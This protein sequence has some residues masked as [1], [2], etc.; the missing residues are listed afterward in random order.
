MEVI[1]DGNSVSPVRRNL[2]AFS[3]IEFYDAFELEIRPSAQ[4]QVF[5]QADSNLLRYITTEVND[6]RLTIQ[7][8]S[9]YDLFPRKPI[10]VLVHTPDISTVDVYGNGIVTIDSLN[11]ASMELNIYSRATVGLNGLEVETMSILSNSGG[12]IYLDGLFENLLF[13]Q[14]GSGHAE[15]RGRAGTAQIIQE[16]SGV[17][18]AQPFLTDS[19]SV[20]LFGSGLIYFL[21]GEFSSVSIDGKGRVY[22]SGTDP[23]HTHIEGGGSI[24][25]N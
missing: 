10:R 24:F 18:D 17:V 15:L 7:R 20:R 1:G 11:A 25:R 8:L 14:A 9:N 22:F 3:E 4:Q 21:S 12:S 23:K 6:D 5:V 13:R 19:V 2:D 16:G